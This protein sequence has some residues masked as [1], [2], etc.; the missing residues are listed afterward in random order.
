MG[1]EKFGLIILLNYLNQM[2][3]VKNHLQL[4]LKEILL[5]MQSS[6]DIVSK[7]TANTILSSSSEMLEPLLGPVQKII[8]YTIDRI[9][10]VEMRIDLRDEESRR[11]KQHIVDSIISAIDDEILNTRAST[12][13]KYKLKVEAL[14][15]VKQVLLNQKKAPFHPEDVEAPSA[16]PA[17]VA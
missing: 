4:A 17:K 11:I 12:S 8:N 7:S 6:L 14:S 13:E 9:T 5:A 1:L 3:Q 10:P 15:T 16:R 2:G